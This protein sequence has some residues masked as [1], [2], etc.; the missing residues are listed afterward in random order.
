MVR[1]RLQHGDNSLR[2]VHPPDRDSVRRESDQLD[3]ALH[4]IIRLDAP[5]GKRFLLGKA[6]CH[7]HHE[8]VREGGLHSTESGLTQN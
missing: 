5:G 6:R 8:G 2:C 1:P 7:Q 3:A 4:D